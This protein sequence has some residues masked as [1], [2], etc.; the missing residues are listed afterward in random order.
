M[1]IQHLFREFGLNFSVPSCFDSSAARGVLFRL[2]SGRLQKLSF[3]VFEGWE[4]QNFA[5]FCPSPAAIFVLSSLSLSLSLW[6]SFSWSCGRSSRPRPTHS[7]RF[8]SL[9]SL[10]ASPG[11]IQA[12]PKRAFGGAMALNR[13]PQIHPQ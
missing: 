8:G 4:A 9:G 2:E 6:G 5:F 12:A 10:C 11:G 3:I 1:G 13:G 7:A